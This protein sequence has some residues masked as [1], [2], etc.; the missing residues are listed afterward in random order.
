[1]TD[2]ERIK[3]LEKCLAEKHLTQLKKLK[4]GLTAAVIALGGCS[5]LE[6]GALALLLYKIF[7]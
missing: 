6:G 4:R 2:E 3:E 7:C 1:M 5:V